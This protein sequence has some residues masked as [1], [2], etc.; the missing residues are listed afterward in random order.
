[1]NRFFISLIALPILAIAAV[2]IATD[3]GAHTPCETECRWV[4]DIDIEGNI[5]HIY[6]CD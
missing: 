1:M 3:G 2:I 6:R 5:E 4:S